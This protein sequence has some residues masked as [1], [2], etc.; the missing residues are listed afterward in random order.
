MNMNYK[1]IDI[2]KTRHCKQYK[3]NDI[4]ILEKN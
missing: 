3:N 4:N 1:N 2:A